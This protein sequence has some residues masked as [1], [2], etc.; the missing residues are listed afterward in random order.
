MEAPLHRHFLSGIHPRRPLSVALL[1]PT[2]FNQCNLHK[3]A[4]LR[5]VSFNQAVSHRFLPKT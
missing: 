3:L 5:G 2:Q 4:P 1:Y